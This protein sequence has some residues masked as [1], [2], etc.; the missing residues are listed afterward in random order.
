MTWHTVVRALA[1]IVLLAAL[2]LLDATR[3]PAAQ[4]CVESLHDLLR[5]LFA[6]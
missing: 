2:L 1:A 6:L 4:A 3:E 5:R